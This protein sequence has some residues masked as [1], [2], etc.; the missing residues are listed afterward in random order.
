[1]R[2]GFN[3]GNLIPVSHILKFC[4]R[5]EDF[6]VTATTLFDRIQRKGSAWRVM[7]YNVLSSAPKEQ[8]KPFGRI[9]RALDPDVILLQEWDECDAM[10]TAAWFSA[11]VSKGTWHVRQSAGRGVAVVSKHRLRR[12]GPY[13][14]PLEEHREQEVIVNNYLGPFVAFV[15]AFAETPRGLLG[16]A[17]IH[18]T[19][20]GE[21]G[22]REDIRRIAEAQAVNDVLR[23]MVTE[24]LIIGG[25]LNLVGSETPREIMRAQADSDETDLAI[26]EVNVIG[27]KED[28]TWRDATSRF[29]PGRLDWLFYSSIHT[30]MVG[31]YVLDCDRVDP[32]SLKKLELLKTDTDHS[33]HLPLVVDLAPR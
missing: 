8:P 21:A 14:L 31:S 7:S 11:N 28:Y 9:F 6:L 25:D 15:G 33:D 1:M 18:L 32:T 30:R 3:R 17:S 10:E 2:V 23:T 4:L 29:P 19:A 27:G 24:H 12:L 20:R 22:S 13:R 16:A 26:A 5:L